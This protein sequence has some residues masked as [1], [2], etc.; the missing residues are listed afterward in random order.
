MPR[1]LASGPAVAR[2]PRPMS[3][4][5]TAPAPPGGS[6]T[7]RLGLGPL[8]IFTLDWPPAVGARSA[9]PWSDA[10]TAQPTRQSNQWLSGLAGRIF[11]SSTVR[12]L[13]LVL[14]GGLEIRWSAKAGRVGGLRADQAPF[15]F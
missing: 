12:P 1:R 6:G 8:D 13:P 9:A 3:T 7:F 10:A 14:P 11:Q 15:T 5:L 4:P 2:E